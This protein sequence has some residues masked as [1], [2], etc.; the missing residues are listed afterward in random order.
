MNNNTVG[1][2][3]T[4]TGATAVAGTD[5]ADAAQ[6]DRTVTHVTADSREV[7]PGS[8]FVALAGER[9]DGHDFVA[10]AVADGAV[11]A[12]TRW[13]VASAVCL[14]VDDPVQALGDIGR[15]VTLQAKE[16]G[17]QVIGIT[18]SAGKTSTKDLL[19]QIL[20]RYAPVVA[21]RESMNNEIGL[22]LTASRC[23]TED[24]FL[25]SEMGAKGLGHIRYLC[26]VTPP[27]VAVELNVGIAHLGRFGDQDTIARAKSELVE[28]LPSDGTAVLNGADHRVQAMASQTAARV[29]N[30]WV[31]PPFDDSPGVG[32]EHAMSP[33]E[34]STPGT[35]LACGLAPDDLDRWHFELVID[36]VAHDVAL[37]LV[38]QHQVTNATAAAA[39]AHAVGVG[40]AS[41][42]TALNEAGSRSHWRMELH[43]LD[44]GAVLINDAYNANP[45]SMR[46]ALSTLRNV[47]ANRQPDRDGRT[48]AVFG[49]MLELGPASQRMHEEIGAA[50][51]GHQVDVLIGVGAGAEPILTGARDAGMPDDHIRTAPDPETV[52]SLL[53][54]LTPGDIVLIKAS[55]DI[56]LESVADA[57]TGGPPD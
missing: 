16:H 15:H 27:D 14:V 49:E 3:V 39:A 33:A 54:D 44:S 46:A 57:L 4:V 34:T 5:P 20:E 9:V 7:G 45:T 25:I 1:E 31:Q 13:P 23:T 41:I 53:D 37:G 38:G 11:A 8:L 17:L 2:L 52:T 35:V 19:A 28:A 10:Q 55:R 56:G 6:L 12:V 40:P 36:G 22:P 51:V 47:A 42:A 30:F 32:D 21:P 50:V 18:G 29:I 48:I 26:E 43:R 24:R